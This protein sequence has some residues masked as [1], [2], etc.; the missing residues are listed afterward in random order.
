MTKREVALRCAEIARTACA[1]LRSDYSAYRQPLEARI[2][3]VIHETAG[4]R[5][6]E[7]IRAYATTLPADQGSVR[8]PI[9]N[10]AKGEKYIILQWDDYWYEIPRTLFDYAKLEIEKGAHE[11]RSTG[12]CLLHVLR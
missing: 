4:M 6:A 2:L 12:M 5:A 11:P 9:R 3:H 8:V 7:A 1:M 10:S